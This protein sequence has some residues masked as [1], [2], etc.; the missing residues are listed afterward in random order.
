MTS[1]SRKYL[2]IITGTF[3]AA[4]LIANTL[5]TKI[6]MLAG[7]SLPAGIILFPLTYLYGDILLDHFDHDTDFN[8][9]RLEESEGDE[10]DAP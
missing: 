10:G 6:F 5:D 2:P 9:F 8:P 3:V 4:L 7:L 1:S